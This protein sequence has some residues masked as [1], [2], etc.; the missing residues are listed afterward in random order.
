MGRG[1]QEADVER[2][3]TALGLGGAVERGF[4]TD[5]AP[6]LAR[7]TVFVSCQ[8]Y[9]NL[10]SSSLLE[11]M[12]SG[13]AVV[14]TDVGQTWRIVD[15]RVG[16][17]TPPAPEALAG[18]IG[19]L[20]DDPAGAARRGLAARERVAARYG[21]QTYVD[22]LLAVYARARRRRAGDSPV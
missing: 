3:L 2:R 21:P 4:A 22:R 10:G 7:S 6:L 16:R 11:A 19:D 20:L 1:E 15:E 14:A 12:A 17:R 18:A 13:N 8:R 5:L 9:E